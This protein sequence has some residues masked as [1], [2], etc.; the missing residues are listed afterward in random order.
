VS[1]PQDLF[2]D[3]VNNDPTYTWEPTLPYK[4]HA[5]VPLDHVNPMP[6]KPAE[7]KSDPTDA[8][9]KAQDKAWDRYRRECRQRSHPYYFET[10]HL[11]YPTRM[12]EIAPP[13]EPRLKL[14]EQEAILVDTPE[15]LAAMTEELKQAK[16]IAVDL[17]Y[18]NTRSYYGFT[19][20]M[21]IST[22]ENDYIVDTLKLRGELRE[23]KL[24]GV[25]ADPSIVKVRFD[26]LL[27]ELVKG[28]TNATG[29]SWL[30]VRRS[31]AATR[32]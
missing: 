18:H 10:E 16:E 22:R 21:Q 29:L 19:C 12:F 6:K 32:L 15:G 14:E 9:R 3:A 4:A 8:Q 20:L 7:K 2:P 17:E 25:M 11:P 30:R 23:D 27:V 5:M 13:I 24:G 31:L 28:L 1:K 26:L